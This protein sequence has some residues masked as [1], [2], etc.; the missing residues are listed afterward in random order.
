M[1]D[2]LPAIQDNSQQIKMFVLSGLLCALLATTAHAKVKKVATP[3]MGWNSYNAYYCDINEEKVKKNAEA[4]VKFGLRDAGYKIVT[5][6]CAWNSQQRDQNGK[7][8]WNATTFPS[9][10]KALGDFLHER[11]LLFGMYS[12]AGY[13]Q[14][15]PYDIVGSLSKFSYF[16]VLPQGIVLIPWQI[17]KTLMPKRLLTGAQTL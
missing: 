5:T 2:H 16:S 6:D 17:M 14:C 15:N 1:P 7:M 3:P 9:G 10:G 8:T 11:G 13:K 12:G 4:L